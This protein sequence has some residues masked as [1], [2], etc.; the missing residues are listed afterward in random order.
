MRSYLQP[1][2]RKYKRKINLKL[3]EN[4]KSDP[5]QVDEIQFISPLGGTVPL[6]SYL[7]WTSQKQL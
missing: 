1:T 7:N 5:K 2:I 6:K 3:D 4:S